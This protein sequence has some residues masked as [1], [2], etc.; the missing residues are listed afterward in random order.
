VTEKQPLGDIED[1]VGELR[2]L[3]ARRSPAT[4]AGVGSRFSPGMFHGRPQQLSPL[5]S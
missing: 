5:L 1:T 3:L 2:R 4:P